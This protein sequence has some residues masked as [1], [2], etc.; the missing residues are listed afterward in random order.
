MGVGKSTAGKKL[1]NK[2]GWNFVDT[3]SIFEEKYKIDIDT[4]FYKYG[5]ELFR[6]LEHDVLT[7]T[8]D[9]QN[10]VISTGGGMPCY[11]DAMT[12]INQNGLSVHITMSEKAILT[13][14]I[15]SKQKRPLVISKSKDELINFVNN[16]LIERNSFYKKAKLTVNAISLNIN[17]LVNDIKSII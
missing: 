4:F 5:E 2:L 16:K 17:T 15:N 13:R 1:A 6:K 10:C 12:L 9:M 8:F 7:S 11:F 3:D 14:L